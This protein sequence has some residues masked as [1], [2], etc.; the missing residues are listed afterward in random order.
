MVVMVLDHSRR[1]F[2]PSV[3][4][5]N[6]AETT[7]ALF[8]TRW[9]THF[10]AP[11][12][13]LLAGVGAF[14]QRA[15]G[16]T[17]RQISWFLLTRGAWLVLLELTVIQWVATFD[18]T[19]YDSMTLQVIWAI[20][21]AMIC[22]AGLVFLPNGAILLIALSTI[23][24]HN[25]LD[26]FRAEQFGSY[27]AVWRL[28][29]DHGLVQWGANKQIM[30][31]YPLV[32]WVAVLALGYALGSIL[33][34][35]QTRRRWL[36]VGLGSA[37]T[38]GFVLLRM[39]NCYGDPTRWSLHADAST[40]VI[41][42]FNCVKNPPSLLFLMMTL[43]PALIMLAALDR[44]PGAIGRVFVM[45][46][47]AALFFYVLHL[48]VLHAAHLFGSR[49]LHLSPSAQQEFGVALLLTYSVWLMTVLLLG[50]LCWWFAEF[51]RRRRDWWLSYC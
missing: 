42:F 30:I 1:Y 43:G 20:G 29:H 13:F 25:L 14:L 17:S 33:T 46:G 6:L 26:G 37:L 19:S 4:P 32:P 35:P 44:P 27:A 49:V 16:M 18:P 39:A 15:R 41:N 23:G 36:L 31:A 48:A 28:L 47:R 45:F 12:F 3:D 21:W 50:P 51:K 8:F 24:L 7:P 40:T 38:V 9:I 2:G 11:T 34:L 5:G 10:C 22:L